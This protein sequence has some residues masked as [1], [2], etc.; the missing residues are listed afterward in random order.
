MKDFGSHTSG[1]SCHRVFTTTFASWSINSKRV[2]L[3]RS[4]DG[5]EVLPT[6]PGLEGR[7]RPLPPITRLSLRLLWLNKIQS[8]WLCCIY[9][10]LPRFALG[11]PPKSPTVDYLHASIFGT[12]STRISSCPG[13]PM[14]TLIDTRNWWATCLAST[15]L[16]GR[17]ASRGNVTGEFRL[18]WPK[19]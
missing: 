8:L 5:K 1:T 6:T 3:T 11:V 4:R 9:P 14:F 12:K 16:S 19:I 7:T 17:V 13:S 18:F 2:A 10:G 15:S